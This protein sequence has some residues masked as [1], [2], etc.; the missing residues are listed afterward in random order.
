MLKN[1]QGCHLKHG[2]FFAVFVCWQHENEFKFYARG[3]N[4]QQK[5]KMKKL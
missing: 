4:E 3:L 5:K 1:S 2:D